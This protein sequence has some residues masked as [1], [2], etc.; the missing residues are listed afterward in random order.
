MKIKLFKQLF[1]VLKRLVFIIL[2]LFFTVQITYSAQVKN[3]VANIE[4]VLVSLELSDAELE[5]VFK[6]LESQ[7][8]FVFIYDTKVLENKNKLSLHYREEPL[9]NVLKNVSSNLKLN[10]KQINGNIFVKEDKHSEQEKAKQ[11][12]SKAIS[13]QVKDEDGNAIPGVSVIV[14]GTYKG[15]VTNIDGNYNIK[16]TGED[17][18]LIFSFLGMSAQ[19]VLINGRERIDV[20]LEKET[21]W[22]N[23]I[24]AVGYGVQKKSDLTGSIVSLKSNEILKSSVGRVD[25]AIQGKISGVYINNSKATPGA[26]PVIRIRGGNS[27]NGNNSPLVVVDGIIDADMSILSPNDISSMEV[28]KDASATAIYGSRGA[29]GVLIITTKKGQVGKTRF[30]LDSYYSISEINKTLDLLNAEETKKLYE[31]FPDDI[32]SRL[33]VSDIDFSTAADTDWQDEIFR[34]AITKNYHLSVSGGSDKIIYFVSGSVLNQDGIIEGSGYKR[35][36]LRCKLEQEVSKKLTFGINLNIA[37]SIQDQLRMDTSGGSS[38]GSVTQAAH[39]MS[40]LVPVYDANGDYSGPL[41]SGTQLNNPVALVKERIRETDFFAT[42]AKIDFTYDIIPELKLMSS[43]SFRQHYSQLNSWSSGV[44]LESKGQGAASVENQKTKDWLSETTL[45]YNKIFDEKH[46]LTTMIGFTASEFS[47]FGS[48]ASGKNFPTES[49]TY[50]SLELSDVAYQRVTSSYL[51]NSMASFLGRINY[52]FDNRYLFTA[53]FRADGASKFTENNKWGYFPSAA[54][55]WRLSEESFLKD[56]DLISNLKFRA[57]LGNTGSQA[58]SEY[59][60]IANYTVVA[61]SLSDGDHIGVLPDRINNPDLKWETTSQTDLGIDLGFLDNKISIVVDYYLKKTKNLHYEKQ[62]PNYTGYTVQL[63][64]IGEIENKG[65]E[66][67]I[68]TKNLR[69]DFKWTTDINFST[70]KNKVISLGDDEFFTVDGSGGAMPSGFSETGIVEVGKQLG[71]FYG[72]EFDG[73]YQ[74]EDEVKNLPASGAVPGAV[75]YKDTDGNHEITPND[76]VVIGDAN[77]DFTWGISNDFS[78]KGFDLNVLFTGIHGNDILNLNRVSLEQTSNA[79]NALKKVL[80]YW[81]GKG[82]SNEIQAAGMSVGQMSSRFVEDGSFVRLKNISLGYTFPKSLTKK[83]KIENVRV[84][85]S[86]QNLVTIT[87][88]TGYDPEINSRSGNVLLGYDFGGYPTAKTFSAG[89]ALNF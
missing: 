53:N 88:Y 42:K 77:P 43:Y 80:N 15:T 50:Y 41:V 63:Q 74:S 13:G 33:G 69:G 31:G 32:K 46:K 56:S 27:I 67:A 68:K 47:N 48:S 70:N 61:V 35:Q 40:P 78:Y 18:L 82:T 34:S 44:L 66:L 39:R 51:D 85:L 38:G 28:L 7:T 65:F 49:L 5:T 36:T 26:S 30:S 20:V 25:Q 23:E 2:L 52:V 84:Y 86:A 22:L 71:Q 11:Q 64:N 45:T 89:I 59:Q 79:N 16:V 1:G 17:Q 12:K 3:K 87:D 29:N 60:S 55:G 21:T 14:K 4:E 57:S 6:N 72:Y 8:N 37:H 24:V 81:H 19:E 62:L 83:L 75:K 54:I 76:R 10:F 73:I 9:S 58:I